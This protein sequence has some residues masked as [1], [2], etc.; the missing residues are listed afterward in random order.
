MSLQQALEL[1]LHH[2]QSGRLAEAESLY[3]RI[4]NVQPLHPETLHFIGILHL[5]RGQYQAALTYLDQ[6]LAVRPDWPDAL[7]NRGEV[8]RAAGRLEE[9]IAAYERAICFNPRFPQ[10][11]NNLGIAWGALGNHAKA[12]AACLKAVEI[13]PGYV[14]AHNNLG[15]ILRNL[16]RLD[17]SSAA[18]HRA[19][20]LRPGYH[21]ALC[22][23]GAVLREMGQLDEAVAILRQA[24]ATK[25]DS[26]EAHYNLGNVLREKGLPDEAADAYRRVTELLPSGNVAEE[27]A[28]EPSG[29][30]GSF[31]DLIDTFRRARLAL[32]PNS[33]D[34]HSNLLLLML[35]QH[36]DDRRIAEEH[37]LWRRQHA[38]P[39][40][41]RMEPRPAN[42]CAGRRLRIGYVS[43]D[44]REHSVSRFLLPLMENHDR[45]KFEIFAYAEV[46]CPDETTA[47]FRVLTDFWRDTVGRGDK[48][49]AELIRADE[50]DILVDLAGHTAGNR[51]PVFARRPAPVQVTWLGYPATTGLDTMTHRL[52]DAHADPPGLTED[53]HSESLCRLPLSAWCF[54]AMDGP[55]VIPRP[56]RGIVFGSF[57]HFAK[58]TDPMLKW[59]A[60]ILAE[61][62]GSSLFLKSAAFADTAACERIRGR[63][64][65]HG[66]TPERVILKGKTRT[67][68]EHLALYQEMDIALDT[69]PYHGTTTTCEALWMGVPVVTLMGTSHRSRVGVSLLGNVGLKQLIATNPE[70]Y[71]GIARSL[72]HDLPELEK[73]RHTLRERMLASPLMDAPRF[74]RDVEN[75]FRKMWQEWNENG[76]R[77]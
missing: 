25:P 6:A 60:R 27:E 53:L 45:E 1:A 31:D 9:A 56:Q 19:I 68:A 38:P 58:L 47:R 50:I 63:F 26:P 28:A 48:E 32:R 66:I 15:G 13:H 52:T 21:Q 43:P 4:L 20:S 22:N 16:G 17:E 5:Q 74:A 2:H 75:A 14:E 54:S 77:P 73:L 55:E 24:V 69:F 41:Q 3:Q 70:E 64:E 61:V 62:P 36:P 11:Y 44:F 49:V 76:H 39:A 51:L 18:Y 40:D 12:L 37:F 10:A 33:A 8:L 71:V 35:Q 7:N 42:A 65:E 29:A 59:W 57:N 34:A 46:P 72:A 23:L 30:R 67:Q